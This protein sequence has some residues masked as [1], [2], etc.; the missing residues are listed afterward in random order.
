M[1]VRSNDPQADTPRGAWLPPL[2]REGLIETRRVP[3]GS[4]IWLSV[5]NLAALTAAIWVFSNQLPW[6]GIGE[7]PAALL[8]AGVF[9]IAGE[10]IGLTVARRDD[11]TTHAYLSM[12]VSVALIATGPIA[13]LVAVQC[14]AV[15]SD[16]LRKRRA[17][18]KVL[19][20]ISQ[21]LL[22]LVAARA[23]FCAL[24]DR[25][26]FGGPESVGVSE[27]VPMVIA[28]LVYVI[29][30]EL[31]VSIAAS[32][33]TGDPLVPSLFADLRMTAQ[34][35][36]VLVG[37]G[38]VVGYLLF[39]ALPLVPL[40]LLPSISIWYSSRVAAQR[41]R[42]SLLDP[43]T[44]LANRAFLQQR[45]ERALAERDAGGPA[46]ALL[47]VDVDH[48]KDVNDVLGHHTGDLLLTELSERAD[49]L[50]RQGEMLARLGGDEFALLVRGETTEV[51]A[52]AIELAEQL[53]AAL[54]EP[55]DLSGIRLSV[56]CS[57]GVVVVSESGL[58]AEELLK[59][60]DI[61]LYE[62]KRERASF[63]VYD[64]AD[65]TRGSAVRLSLLAD[66]RDAVSLREL[67]VRFQPQVDARLGTIVGVEA[68]CRWRHNGHGWLS[69]SVF[70][71]IA[72]SA[73]LIEPLTRH[74]LTESLRA[75]RT[76][77]D[78]GLDLQ[79]AVNLSTRLV[80]DRS[81]PTI[82]EATL[83]EF[84]VPAESLTIEVTE[85][86]VVTDPTRAV[87]VLAEL[88]RIGVRLAMDDFGTGYSSLALLQQLEVDELKVDR[89]FVATMDSVPADR[90]LVR[91]TVDLAHSL[92]LSVVAEGVE[93][94]EIA[95][96]LARMGCDRMQGY[97][98]GAAMTVEEIVT[99]VTTGKPLVEPTLVDLT[100]GHDAPAS[101][102]ADGKPKRLPGPRSRTLVQ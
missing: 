6:S 54:N 60:A 16:D 73:G 79:V 24:T 59:R 46:V 25:A 67:E 74:V 57:V 11:T 45:L 47:M 28:G 53:L 21:Y 61:A 39:N 20:N 1:A 83:A 70:I 55:L 3:P 43:L 27:A 101:L 48:F 15:A 88:R 29:L 78:H 7:A 2:D 31:Q 44:G 23:V 65:V 34:I 52:R 40:L 58:D 10:H 41:H 92:G 93:R 14:G 19:F 64:A 96:E 35:T 90:I 63:A 86:G 82:V 98:F 68:L 102:R 77:A 97:L 87:V 75:A 30:N 99:V 66:L 26:V 13:F 9:I 49:R 100:D 18:F 62:A 85:S 32:V 56:Q 4:W 84:D 5:V 80:S 33:L 76:W 81:L 95:D 37:M 8:L 22:A 71:P 36:F 94:R 89:S 72:E 42:V 17:P 12:A 50:T 38:P 91:S 69:P 51:S